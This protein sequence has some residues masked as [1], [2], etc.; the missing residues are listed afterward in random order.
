VEEVQDEVERQL[1]VAGLADVARALVL[2]RRRRAELREA[3]ALPEVRDELKL[4]LAAV[5]VLRHRYLRRDEQG[6][7]IEST[8]EMLDRVAAFVAT[9]ED[10]HEPGA[11]AQWAERFSTLLRSLDFLPNSP[12][13][14]NAGTPLGLLSGCVVLPIEDSLRSIFATLGHS[15]L[16]HQPGGGTGYSFSPLRPAGDRVASTGGIA[17]GPL[18]FVHLFDAAASVVGEGGRRRSASMAVLDV[19]HPDIHDFVT[20]KSSGGG[21]EHFNLSVG[22]TDTFLRAVDRAGAHRLVNPRNGRTVARTPATELFDAIC[23]SAHRCGDPG[24]LFLDTINRANPLPMAGR[25]EATNPCGEVPLLPHE[26]CNLGSLNLAHFAEYGQIDWDRLAAAVRLAVRF[27]DDVIDV[28]RYPID[29]L[30]DAAH[31]T[32][33][34]G[35]GVMGLAELLAT[36]GVAHDSDAAVRLAGQLARHIRDQARLASAELAATRGPF[37]R[38]TDSTYAGSGSPPLR[39]AQL[40]SVAPTGTI[41]LIAATTAGIEP[42]F[43]IAYARNVLGRSSSRPTPSSSVSPVIA[44]STPMTSSTTSPEPEGCGPTDASPTTSATRSSPHSRPRRSGICGCRRRSNATSMGPS[45]R[46]STCPR[47]PPSTTSVRSSWPHGER[48]SR[49]SPST[50]TAPNRAKSSPCSPPPTAKHSHRSRSTP[51]SP[52][53]AGPTSASSDRESGLRYLRDGRLSPGPSALVEKEG[54]AH[55]DGMDAGFARGTNVDARDLE[56]V[57]C[58]VSPITTRLLGEMAGWRGGP[59]VSIYVPLDPTR[60]GCDADRVALKDAVNDARRQLETETSLRPA[61]VDGLLAPAETLVAGEGWTPG[62]RGYGL[63]AAPGRSVELRLHI[64]VPYVSVGADRFVVTP[65]VAA[66]EADDRFYVLAVSQNR[67]RLSRGDRDRLVDVAVPGL[68]VSRAE[69]LWYEDQER[70]L[71]VHG[72]NRLGAGRIVGTLHGS[73]SDRDL[74]KRQLRR[75]FQLVDQAV[76][77]SLGGEPWPLFVAGVGYELSLYRDVSHYPHLAG[78]IDVGNPDRLSPAELHHQIWP[79]VAGELDAPRRDLLARINSTTP[80]T[81]LPAILAACDEGR[82]AALAVRP[83]PLLWGSL[84]PIEQH[85]ERL[86][87]DVDLASAVIGAALN[88][89]AE[90]YPAARDELPRGTVLAALPRY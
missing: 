24:L 54:D 90:V 6:R 43:A 68:P 26:S 9:A 30:T 36:L 2:Y 1:M 34:V 78:V 10:A 75:F 22:V 3:K 39:N 88:Q 45:Q 13:L 84:D 31:A 21:V 38:F 50:G 23:E 56:G 46:R 20:A 51:G 7:V 17:S 41:S 18:S 57:V 79:T 27:L 37:P 64:D 15:A 42:I 65:L 74:R 5:T 59:C 33:K 69:A 87:G 89:G 12:T 48:V 77:A 76:A 72:G 63:L 73:P 32:R 82:V 8:G 58:L 81:S 52:A 55:P 19:R 28:S 16:V 60:P 25:I 14:M 40:T 35:L 29:E 80:M 67:V 44:A 62:H 85:A 70:Q 11:S 4:S 47:T 53:D 61:A 86:P 83:E 49:G 71:N 66:L